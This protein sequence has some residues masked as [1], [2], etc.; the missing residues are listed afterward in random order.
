MKKFE[1]SKKRSAYAD[2]TDF[3]NHESCVLDL[4]EKEQL[5]KLDIIYR[6]LV[7]IL[8]NFVPSSGHPGGSISS[9]RIVSSLI[10]KMMAYELAAPHRLDA[11]ILSYAAGHKALGM[12]ALWALRNECVR[13]AA[14][15]L[16]AQ[17]EQDQLRLEDLLGFR[18]NKV[19]GTPLFE[20]G[21]TNSLL[22][23]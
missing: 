15:E 1:F 17:K 9:G 4:Q 6:A 16:L 10:Y 19:Q 5:E 2:V 3:L 14:P 20:K 7:A 13:L 18:R 22:K 11:D 21:W 8:Y 23:V 12:Y